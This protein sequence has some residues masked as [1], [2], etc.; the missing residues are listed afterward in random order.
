M[1]HFD[2]LTRGA[3]PHILLAIFSAD[4]HK[5]CCEQKNNEGV[6]EENR[7]WTKMVD[8]DVIKNKKTDN[9]L[10]DGLGFWFQ[11][12]RT[13]TGVRSRKVADSRQGSVCRCRSSLRCCYTTLQ[14]TKTW[15]VLHVV[16]TDFPVHST[17]LVMGSATLLY[18]TM[19][20]LYT[21][22]VV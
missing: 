5:H 4:R 9:K 3:H 8:K 15:I 12:I 2:H 20:I 17:F 19:Y 6:V 1:C 7:R 10:D 16:S 11:L 22:A 13:S 14:C 21:V 18:C